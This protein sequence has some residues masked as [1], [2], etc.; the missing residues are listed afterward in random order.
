MDLSAIEFDFYS[1]MASG[2]FPNLFSELIDTTIDPDCLINMLEPPDD[3]EL[4]EGI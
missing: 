2:Y 1:T 3:I 4:L